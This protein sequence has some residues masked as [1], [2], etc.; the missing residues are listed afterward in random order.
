MTMTCL[1]LIGTYDVVV[2]VGAFMLNHIRPDCFQEICRI[3]KPG[4][5]IRASTSYIQVIWARMYFMIYNDGHA[6]AFYAKSGG[7]C[8]LCFDICDSITNRHA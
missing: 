4:R 1:Y 3:V 6:W 7:V 5:L 8:F 2:S